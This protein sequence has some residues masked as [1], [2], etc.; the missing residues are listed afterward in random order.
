MNSPGNENSL[1]FHVT[2]DMAACEYASRMK[3]LKV[4]IRMVAEH[5]D[6]GSHTAVLVMDAGTSATFY[7]DELNGVQDDHP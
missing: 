2:R 3:V 4:P 6:S 5:W 1:K 7:M